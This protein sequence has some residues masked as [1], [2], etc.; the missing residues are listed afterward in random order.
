[1]Y[2]LRESNISDRARYVIAMKLREMFN[3]IPL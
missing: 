1:M 3:E 2:A